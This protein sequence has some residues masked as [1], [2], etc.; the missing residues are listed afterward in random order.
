MVSLVLNILLGWSLLVP[1]SELRNF[2]IRNTMPLRGL[3][4]ILIICHHCSQYLSYSQSYQAQLIYNFF[5]EVGAPIVTV[6]FFITGYGLAKSINKKGVSYLDGFLSKRLSSTLPELIILSVLVIIAS[7]TFGH[8]STLNTFASKMAH[9]EAPLAFSWFIY[10][11]C[12]IYIA[13]YISFRICKGKP[14]AGG[15]L[16]TMLTAL[17]AF[18][19]YQLNWGGHWYVSTMSVSFGYWM[20]LYENKLEKYIAN[21]LTIL[22]FILI[23]YIGRCHSIFII[24]ILANCFCAVAVYMLIRRFGFPQ[25][26]IL[27]F[28]G[29]ISLNIYLVHELFI[30]LAFNLH[31]HGSI[32]LGT[33]ITLSVAAA[34]LMNLI[35][36]EVQKRL[37]KPRTAPA[38]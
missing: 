26:R 19:P 11:I 20:S 30:K 10:I 18:I 38:N 5:C 28:L 34:F 32:A 1:K 13:F 29:G 23:W 35:R 33:V 3:L 37:S 36:T 31:L 8:S 2:D 21:P 15:I 27:I 7:I 25:S 17:C 16:F 14:V 12:L 22:A 24:R 6:F 9:G 4:A